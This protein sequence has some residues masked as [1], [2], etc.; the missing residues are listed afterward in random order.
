MLLEVRCRI[1]LSQHTHNLLH[2]IKTAEVTAN[3]C[4][5]SQTCTA[6][7]LISL[8]GCDVGPK[9]PGSERAID[10]SRASAR[11]E[12]E[13]TDLRREKVVCDGTWLVLRHIYSKRF[14]PRL[15]TGVALR[16]GGARQH[17]DV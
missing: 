15:G 9:L 13:I 17:D 8:I 5:R 4:Q 12:Q 2:A 10:I 16:R 6:G 1:Y 7:C 14:Q 3:G 11:H